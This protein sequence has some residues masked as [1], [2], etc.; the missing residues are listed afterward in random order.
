[1]L[2]NSTWH[3]T[4]KRSGKKG[5]PFKTNPRGE[6]HS[7]TPCFPVGWCSPMDCSWVSSRSRSTSQN[8]APHSAR[9]SG[10]P[11][12]CSALDIPWNFTGAT[13]ALLFSRTGLVGPVPKGRWRLFGRIFTMDETW[14]RSYEPNLKRQS[15]EWK[16]ISSKV[17]APYTMCCGSDV[18]CDLSHWWGY[19]ALRCTSKADSKRCLL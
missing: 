7:S 6:Q 5:I 1:M 15:N 19:T 14:V 3:D 13:M 10:L 18:H 17:G 11:Q 8:C 4:L 2:P 9:H 16:H 12:T